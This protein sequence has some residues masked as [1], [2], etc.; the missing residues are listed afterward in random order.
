M[1]YGQGANSHQ[2]FKKKILGGLAGSGDGVW[3]PG[4]VGGNLR[5]SY[6]VFNFLLV[7]PEGKGLGSWG[8]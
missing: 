6:Q 8:F 2:C 1:V 3:G 7:R 5:F 4:G